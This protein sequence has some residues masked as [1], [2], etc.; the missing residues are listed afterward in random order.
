[1]YV[2]ARNGEYVSAFRAYGRI[3]AVEKHLNSYT[4]KKLLISSLL[5]VSATLF[6]ANSYFVGSCDK[7]ALSY[8]PG[9]TMKFSL[10][11]QN[12]K[13]EI[14]E[15]QKVKW[16]RRG[17]D[18]K[19]FSGEAVSG[20]DPIVIE[21]SISTPGFVR[22]TATP[23][24]ENGKKV[25]NIDVFDGGACAAF[26]RIVQKTPE[27]ADFD[28]FWQRQ[29]DALKKVPMKCGR[30]EVAGKKGFKTY[31]LTI[32]CVGKPAKAYLTIPENAKA[33]SLPLWVNV[34]G[35][36]VSRIN[37]PYKDGCIMLS[38]ARHSYELG[39]SDEYYKQQKVKLARF[40]LN[41]EKNPEN[42]Y[43]KFMIL[44]DLRAIEYAKTL[45]EWNGKDITVSGGSMGGFQSI[46]VAALDKDITLCKPTIPWMC[47]LN[48]ENEGRQKSL[49]KPAYTPAVLY[50]DSTN[51]IKRVKCPVEILAYLGDYVCPPT[52]IAVLYNNANPNT[53]I[54]FKQNG[55]HGYRSPWKKNPTSVR[56][57]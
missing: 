55:T 1:M 16:T 31:V 2:L 24:D 5:F 45:P 35:Y 47:N 17:D 33:K 23:V 9:E 34:H 56:K 38:V 37:P 26:G 27:P 13:G 25:K 14:V 50:F 11:I 53:K 10:N 41:A 54:V 40:G 3:A 28:A 12:D 39:Q 49:F 48:A 46:F 42:N 36:G 6:A 43:F 8:K 44:R 30:K 32:D 29:L 7:G 57:K 19:T 22:I 15:G 20:K 51:A 18:G 21:T 4:M 52:G